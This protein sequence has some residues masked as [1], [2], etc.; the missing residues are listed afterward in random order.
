MAPPA[1]VE[2]EQ[3]RFSLV[4][5]VRADASTAGCLESIG[6]QGVTASTVEVVVVDG[7]GDDPDRYAETES[8]FAGSLAGCRTRRL[9]VDRRYL[10]EAREIGLAA[11]R[12]ANRLV[13]DS[14]VPVAP[15]LLA[16]LGG[17]E[18]AADLDLGARLDLARGLL[19]LADGDPTTLRR[20]DEVLADQV[21]WIR[22][23][24]DADPEAHPRVVAEARARRV[25]ELPW[26]E[27]NR[28]RARDL[29]I[30]FCFVPFIDTSGLVAAR[31][32]REAGIVTDVVSQD[33]SNSRR[34][35][36]VSLRI[37]AE[38]L[39]ELRMLPG[40][41]HLVK[42]Q[43]G[44]RFAESALEE[45]AKLE[46]EKGPYRSV[47]SRAMNQHSHFAAAILKLR[48][49]EIR[50]VAEFSDPLAY[51]AYGESRVG[52]V[53]DDWL[54]EELTAGFRR[55]G[56]EVPAIRDQFAWAELVAYAFADEIIYTNAHQRDLMLGYCSDQ[57]LA[58]R[59]RGITRVLH[60]PVPGADLYDVVAPSY[61]LERERVHIGFFG[62][63]YPNR[64]LSEVM[65][66][67]GRLGPE[68][69][70]RVQLHVFTSKPLGLRR[71]V[72]EAGLTGVIVI[73]TMLGYLEYLNLSTRFDVLL[74]NDYATSPHFVPNP[75]LPAKLADYR[76][77]GA[78]IW[79][80]YEA[81]SVLSSSDADFASPLGD[82]DSATAVLRDMLSDVVGG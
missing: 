54:I 38:V 5:V 35:D 65:D 28:G 22:E 15:G 42:W 2:L 58:A 16:L 80:L 61:R 79:A 33:M 32:L 20:R 60:H 9:T 48:Q 81:G 12:G 37:P 76:G 73:N 27:I 26:A 36:P 71:L 57:A 11:A 78:R 55:H 64:G 45:V 18:P 40:K 21:S 23:L 53:E 82:T 72:E 56:H 47:Y 39:D 75:Y 34:T 49:P 77:S 3:P 41:R 67:L 19:A 13:L 74:I 25:H 63:F 51:N 66:A 52:D 17:A 29:A 50:W 8:A 69:R 43:A 62:N 14:S 46:G 70:D 68:E 30:L 6:A 44:R 31:R 24:L 59:A 7:S 4:V 10:H 1:G